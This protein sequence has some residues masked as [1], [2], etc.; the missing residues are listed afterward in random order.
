MFATYYQSVQ[1]QHRTLFPTV[2]FN[3]SC[4]LGTGT[5]VLPNVSMQLRSCTWAQQTCVYNTSLV[6]CPSFSAPCFTPGI[7]PPCSQWM[8][9]WVT[10]PESGNHPNYLLVP[11]PCT[12]VISR[13]PAN[14]PSVM[15][16]ESAPPPPP[17]SH[18]PGS[19]CP[20]SRWYC[21]NRP[22]SSSP[23]HSHLLQ[24]SNFSKAQSWSCP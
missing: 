13:A 21:W 22:D 5:P 6:G 10:T 2:T 7:P 24:T 11:H 9:Q 23:S 19:H 8:H 3:H 20:V 12:F 15:L 1:T 17:H 18:R 4:G 16:F 14:T